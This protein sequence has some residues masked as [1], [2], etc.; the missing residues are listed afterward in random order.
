MGN[1]G[2]VDARGWGLSLSRTVADGIHA[3]IDYTHTDAEWLRP[4]A[5]TGRLA[6]VMPSVVRRQFEQLHDVTTSIDSELP[7]FDTHVF[8]IYKLNSGFTSPD[9]AT[10]RPRFGSRFDVEVSQALPFLDFAS[11]QWQMI[12]AV[13]NLFQEDLLETSVYSVISPEGCAV[14]L[15]KDAG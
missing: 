1:T 9:A 13:R 6:L 8:V 2:D 3:S 14:I 12:I 10:F 11:A 5:T 4:T 7:R 15:W